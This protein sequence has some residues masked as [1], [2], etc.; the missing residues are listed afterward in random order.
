M[1]KAPTVYDV[2]ERAGVSIASVSRVLRSPDSVKEQTRERVLEAVRHLG[3]VPSANARGL[4]ARRTNVIG[5]FFPG[6]DDVAGSE[7]QLVAASGGVTTVRDDPT[8]E[9]ETNN[10]YFDEVL[11]GAEIEAWRRGFA[12]MVAAGRG[13]SRE[14]IV[15]DIAGRV[16][17]LAVLARTVPDEL[18][19]HVARRIPVVVLAAT[20]GT[21][22]FDHVSV[23]NAPGMR[24][25][26]EHVLKAGAR[27]LLYI[28]GPEDSPDDAERLQGFR[29]ALDGNAEVAVELI[30]GDFS[31]GRGRE[32]A[33][34]IDPLPDAIVCSNDQ[35]ALGVLDAMGR[36]SISVPD[37]V[38]VTGFD[39]IA[40]GRHSSPRLTT[41]HQPMVE[42]GRAAIQALT[43]R[44]DD[45][46]MDARS[47]V[48]PVQVVLR[49][50]CP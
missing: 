6:H 34:G 28:A 29:A 40:A 43:A 32:I 12:L 37:D 25:M 31:R 48:L 42:L 23:N 47:L 10:F 8:T 39:G 19:T 30:R 16:D 13:A 33:L 24:A 27:S 26:T 3:Y 50:S 4:A 44:F 2:A 11:R 5:L 14:A 9:P 21:D 18:L 46:S 49:E 38:M 7:G 20:R 1:A 17:G 35:T 15:N 41:V 45:P 36:R 22:A